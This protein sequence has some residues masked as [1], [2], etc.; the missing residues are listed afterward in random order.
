MDTIAYNVKQL[1]VRVERAAVLYVS[2]KIDKA[3]SDIYKHFNP[4]RLCLGSTRPYSAPA[5]RHYRLSDDQRFY[6]NIVLKYLQ[7]IS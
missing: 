1:S 2:R 4:A 6:L 7:A 3:M 5:S